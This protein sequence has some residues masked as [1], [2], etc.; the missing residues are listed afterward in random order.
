MKIVSINQFASAK[1]VGRG[2]W[3]KV[4][5]LETEAL[6]IETDQQEYRYSMIGYAYHRLKEYRLAKYNFAK[7]LAHDPCC[8]MALQELAEVYVEEKNHEMGYQYVLKG[9][10]NVKE[11][12]YTVPKHIKTIIAVMLKIFRPSRSYNE[13]RE[14]TEGMDQSRNEWVAWANEYKIWYEENYGKEGSPLVH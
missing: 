12:D 10:N 7:A 14:E 4:I 1:A 9:L 13:I 8:E 3:H 11:F 6:S 2:D 5:E